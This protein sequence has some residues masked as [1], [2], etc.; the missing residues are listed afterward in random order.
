MLYINN[1]QITILQWHH[2]VITPYKVVSGNGHPYVSYCSLNEEAHLLSSDWGWWWRCAGWTCAFGC[3]GSGPSASWWSVSKGR[4]TSVRFLL[5]EPPDEHRPT[6]RQRSSPCHW[7]T[8]PFGRNS[9]PWRWMVDWRWIRCSECYPSP[10]WS[11][12]LAIQTLGRWSQRDWYRPVTCLPLR[13]RYLVWSPGRQ[14]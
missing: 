12:P 6:A 2:N 3:L 7:G 5:L 13:A 11:F 4:A 10:D 1:T 14:P 8:A 9:P